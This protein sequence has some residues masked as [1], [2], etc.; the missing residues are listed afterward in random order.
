MQP[1]SPPDPEAEVFQAGDG[2]SWLLLS[3]WTPLVIRESGAETRG[4]AAEWEC[5]L[6]NHVQLGGLCSCFTPA[7]QGLFYSKKDEIEVQTQK[8][9]SPG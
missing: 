6:H 5:R 1:V 2:D 4:E 3:N 7:P 8:V 9:I